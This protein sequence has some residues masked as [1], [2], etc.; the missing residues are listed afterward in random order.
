M[1]TGYLAIVHMNKHR[2]TIAA[3]G[4][5]LFWHSLSPFIKKTSLKLSLCFYLLIKLYIPHVYVFFG[6]D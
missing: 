6:R 5:D 2:A 3:I 4:K 1:D